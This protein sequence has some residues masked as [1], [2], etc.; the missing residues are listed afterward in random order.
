MFLFL[1]NT[2]AKLGMKAHDICDLI[3][4]D[5]KKLCMERWRIREKEENRTNGNIWKTWVKT[6]E[7][8]Y[9]LV[10]IFLKI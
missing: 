2:L 5:Y 1:G 7:L 9:R 4:N 8:N 3:S 6:M 10:P